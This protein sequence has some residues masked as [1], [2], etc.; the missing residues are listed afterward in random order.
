MLFFRKDKRRD[1]RPLTPV[2]KRPPPG[3]ID[4]MQSS[5]FYADA[6]SYFRDY[7]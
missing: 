4:A 2:T 7:P 6:F 5:A 3:S 1:V